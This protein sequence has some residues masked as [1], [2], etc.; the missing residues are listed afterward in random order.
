MKIPALY[1]FG[2]TLT[3]AVLSLVLFLTGLHSDVDKF[4]IGAAVG[5]ILGL[6]AILFFL[7]K[8]IKAVRTETGA[9]TGFSY[10]RA[11]ASGL[12]IMVFA[13]VFSAPFNYVYFGYINSGYGETSIAW[14][15]RFMEKANVPQFKIDETVE[16]MRLKS[17]PLRQTTNGV[18]G[19]LV[20]GAIASLIA[21]AV[22]K[23]APEEAMPPEL[24][25]PPQAV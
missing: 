18:V 16:K 5:F 6:S 7:I 4:I 24:T 3:S 14:T 12:M 17:T 20:I 1:G 23:R 8:G 15:T 10:G 19:T 11:F 9:A 25:E 22:M 13:A 21:A 2:L